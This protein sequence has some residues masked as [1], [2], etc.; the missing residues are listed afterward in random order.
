MTAV[1]CAVVTMKRV[2]TMAFLLCSMED[3]TIPRE[4][5]LLRCFKIRAQ[6]ECCRPRP[7]AAATAAA[8]GSSSHSDDTGSQ[9]IPFFSFLLFF[10]FFLI[11]FVLFFLPGG[12]L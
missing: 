4:L 5:K 7:K 3:S 2:G 1:R 8:R 9:D 12:R 6:L 11:F 10:K